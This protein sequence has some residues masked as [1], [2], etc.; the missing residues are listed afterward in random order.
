MELPPH[1]NVKPAER[2]FPATLPP[3]FLSEDLVTV[4]ITLNMTSYVW[5]RHPDAQMKTIYHLS[6][7]RSEVRLT[8]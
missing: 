1:G 6:W 7:H 4:T 5:K 2:R 8:L 3:I